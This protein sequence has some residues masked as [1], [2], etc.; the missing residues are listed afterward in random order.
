M[1]MH[2]QSCGASGW[3]NHIRQH[4]RDRNWGTAW[5]DRVFD[6]FRYATVEHAL[7]LKPV[8][9]R[10]GFLAVI[11]FFYALSCW[12]SF[13]YYKNLDDFSTGWPLDGWGWFFPCRG[14]HWQE[15]GCGWI[16]PLH[17]VGGILW[18]VLYRCHALLLGRLKTSVSVLTSLFLPFIFFFRFWPWSPVEDGALDGKPFD[19]FRHGVAHL[20][21]VF[22]V[23]SLLPW[24]SGW[25]WLFGYRKAS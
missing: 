2:F 3:R 24:A 18:P 1:N 21:D 10:P 25:P 14:S 9:A 5:H 13:R 7:S 12:F 15:M 23:R 17:H 4:R 22:R 11:A 6:A 20:P 16:R 19:D 8:L